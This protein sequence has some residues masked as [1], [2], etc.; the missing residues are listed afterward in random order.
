MKASFVSSKDR[1]IVT[2]H[3]LVLNRFSNNLKE[4]NSGTRY[5]QINRDRVSKFIDLPLVDDEFKPRLLSF[6]RNVNENE[7]E[8]SS[9]FQVDSGDVRSRSLFKY[10]S[11][12]EFQKDLG[13]RS[14][15][16]EGDGSFFDLWLNSD[17]I[18]SKNNF[19]SQGLPKQ[20]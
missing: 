10:Q 5:I 19:D 16:G 13:Y 4:T 17:V 7:K 15:F 12:P 18:A 3:D 20:G 11:T 6:N 2:K 14:R 1:Q 8:K 9:A